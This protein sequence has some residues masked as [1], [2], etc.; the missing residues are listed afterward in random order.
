MKV[1]IDLD[2]QTKCCEPRI[3]NVY[4]RRGGRAARRGEMAVII[5]IT[6]PEKINDK[7][8]FDTEMAVVIFIDTKGNIVGA[9]AHSL[10]YYRD[11]CPIAF[12]EGFQ[13]IDINISS[14]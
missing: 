12:A 8:S 6:E 13:D 14:L 5:A 2:T 7:C 1:H 9:D 4:A 11:K 10:S 3:G